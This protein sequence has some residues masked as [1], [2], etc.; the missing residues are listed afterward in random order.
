MLHTENSATTTQAR[1]LADYFH[2]SELATEI[3]KT[4]RTLRAWRKSRKG[5]PWTL[6]G[7]TVIYRREAFRK[8]LLD[9]EQQPVRPRHT[10]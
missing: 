1:A 6:L 2:E 4:L 8:W 5:P 7:G 10:R 3:K 9:Q